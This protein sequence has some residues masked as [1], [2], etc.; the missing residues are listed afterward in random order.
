MKNATPEMKT[1]L[2]EDCTT[3]CR[4]Y[5]IT[6]TDGAVFTF[7]DHDQDV[8]TTDFQADIPD[9]G[10]VYEAA[11]GFSPTATESKSDLS[12]D[13]QEATCFID[14]E[15][16]TEKDLRFGIWDAADV[17]IRIVNWADLTMGAIKMRKGQMGNLTLKNGVLTTELL[18]L[19][20]KLQILIGRTFSM[21]CDAELGDNRCKATV[22]VEDGAVN[23]NA[24]IGLND[25]HHITP[26][27]GLTGAA[28]YYDD[29]VVTFDAGN[30][31]GLSFQIKEWDGI[32]FTL[33][34][35][36]FAPCADGDT[37]TVKPGCGHN[38]FDCQNKFDNIENH[39]GFPAIPG[40]DSILLYP[41]STG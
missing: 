32:T 30:N 33:N 28:G 34:M 9:G 11:V 10:Y 26:Y 22:P 6:R 17:E 24:S 31:S 23:T 16:I 29:G 40:Q 13:N 14:S 27:S 39:Q 8:D 35:P 2:A 3:L 25:P 19:S 36:L 15:Q 41:D 12:V 20:N 1:H 21:S 37:F 7:T 38:T 5:K 4:L 18:G